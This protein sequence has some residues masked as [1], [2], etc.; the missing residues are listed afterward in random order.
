MCGDPGN[1]SGSEG[2]ESSA[3]YDGTGTYSNGETTIWYDTEGEQH[4]DVND[5]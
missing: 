1:T 4:C 3:D 2:S 5:N